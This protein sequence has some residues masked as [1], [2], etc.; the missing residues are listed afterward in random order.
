MKYF[1]A[2]PILWF[3]L[4]NHSIVQIIQ[5]PFKFM[6][7]YQVISLS[8]ISS[9]SCMY[10]DWSKNITRNLLSFRSLSSITKSSIIISSL[11]YNSYFSPFINFTRN[12][13]CIHNETYRKNFCTSTFGDKHHCVNRFGRL[14]HS[15][16]NKLIRCFIKHHISYFLF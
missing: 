3:S 14:L 1:N 10:A 6:T 2:K 12:Y 13:F 5:K 16:T 15:L 7:L 9:R 8:I 11:G 4:A